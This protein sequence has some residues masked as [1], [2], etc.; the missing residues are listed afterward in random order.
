MRYLRLTGAAAMMLAVSYAHASAPTTD[1]TETV[2]W[3]LRLARVEQQVAYTC[4][5]E[6]YTLGG[7]LHCTQRCY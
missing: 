2:D 7:T 3:A 4:R 5:T 1:T 6:C